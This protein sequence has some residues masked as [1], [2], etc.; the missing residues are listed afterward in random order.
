MHENTGKVKVS[1]NKKNMESIV[2]SVLK[3]ANVLQVPTTE[4][5]V[6]RF[7]GNSL[8]SGLPVLVTVDAR[9]EQLKLTVNCEKM[10]I[11]TMLMKDVKNSFENFA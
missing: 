1:E 8:A 7:A 3:A 2:T 11:G 4:E 5:N 6:Y 10:V 9:G